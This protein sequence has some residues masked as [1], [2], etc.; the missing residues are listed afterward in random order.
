MLCK[1]ALSTS[2]HVTHT[3]LLFKK[4]GYLVNLVLHDQTTWISIRLFSIIILTTQLLTNHHAFAA[5]EDF[6][7]ITNKHMLFANKS[8]CIFV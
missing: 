6:P 3:I 5:N 4:K 7:A 1:Y 2:V 8:L